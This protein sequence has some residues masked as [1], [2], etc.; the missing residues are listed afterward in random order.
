M[1]EQPR[2]QPG[3]PERVLVAY[4]KVG[5][6]VAAH[7]LGR[8]L[9]TVSVAGDARERGHAAFTLSPDVVSEL[10]RRL[11]VPPDAVPQAPTDELPPAGGPDAAPPRWG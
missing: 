8:Q 2:T 3:A 9:L 10:E 7:L 11:L 6:A 4:H 1:P 5:H